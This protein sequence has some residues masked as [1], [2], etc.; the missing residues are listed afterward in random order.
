MIDGACQLLGQHGQRFA[1]SVLFL[2]SGQ[3]LLAGRIVPQK[4]HGGFGKF[5]ASA[6]LPMAFNAAP[7]IEPSA[8]A[9][10]SF[11]LE[12]ICIPSGVRRLIS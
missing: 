7:D 2:Q 9:R 1:L 6:G 8:P 5:C 12:I 10:S 4:Q 11:R 3:V